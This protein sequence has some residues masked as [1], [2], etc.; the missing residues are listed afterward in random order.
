MIVLFFL[1]TPVIVLN[2]MD[3]LK[4]RE[5]EKAVSEYSCFL[6]LAVS[7]MYAERNNFFYL[8]ESYLIRVYA[9][10]TVVDCCCIITCIS[11]KIGPVA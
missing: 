10:I 7:K 6:R 3:T 8:T 5:I 1:T 4:L 9:Y 2:V 11:Y